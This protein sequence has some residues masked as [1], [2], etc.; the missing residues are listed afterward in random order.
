MQE[1]HNFDL[2]YIF[3]VIFKRKKFI[4]GITGILL[5]VALLVSLIAPKQ[6][7]SSAIFIVKNP[8]LLD[9]N[10]IFRNQM[11]ENKEF[12]AVPDDVDQVEFIS[13]SDAM[14]WYL[15]QELD[16]AKH[17]NIK[18]PFWLRLKVKN[19]FA[20]SRQ[21][22]KN[23]EIFYTDKDPEMSRKVTQAIKDYLEDRFTKYF[24]KSN[25]Q[26][27]NS[28]AAESVVL[29]STVTALSTSINQI[30]IEN[31]L[32]NYL[33]PTRTQTQTGTT[34]GGNLNAT[35][36]TALENLHQ[37]TTLKDQLTTDQAKYQSLMHEFDVLEKGDMRMF[38]T[39]QDAYTPDE[40]SHPKTLLILLGTLIG[41]LFIT[42]IIAV[43]G[44]FYKERIKA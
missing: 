42:S 13:K 29:D 30:R 14:I 35:Q 39:V 1:Q 28:L 15:I 37:L 11:F 4:L 34:G 19:N 18:S 17:Y 5:V 24:V 27:A 23:I 16:L 12:F 21:D 44:A 10:Y 26:I 32:H 41:G 43:F 7:T 40:S 33:L 2:V 9:R 22:T 36:L 3:R 25:K 8:I 38:Y 31:N 6:Y 20:F